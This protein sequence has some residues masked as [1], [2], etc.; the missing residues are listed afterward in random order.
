MSDKFRWGIIATGNIS[1]QFARGLAALPEAELLAVGSRSQK[2]ADTFGEMFGVPRRYDSYEALIEDP[3]IEAVYIGAPHTAHAENSLRCIRN[4]KAV[5]CEKPFAINAAQAREVID[6]ARERRVFVMEAVWTRFLPLFVRLRDLLAQGVIGDV[7]L[8]TADFGFRTRFNPKGRLFDPQ[9]G[10]GALLDVGIYPLSLASLILGQPE[11]ITG[12]ANLGETGID[13]DSAVL[14][15]YPNGALAA[16]TSAIRTNTPQVAVL[17]GTEGRITIHTRWWVGTHMTV[18][19]YGKETAEME[20]P[21]TGNGYNYEAAEVARCV[22]SGLLE[23]EVMPLDETLAVM[24]MM[25]EL[26]AQWGLKYPME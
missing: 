15:R 19:I 5:L 9:L 20:L 17:N 22:R 4:G 2:S 26:R 21:L 8:I 6:L 13:E 1:R 18:E 3:D 24:Q 11:Q 7:R 23:S 14:L 10:G 25:D 16:L 12:L